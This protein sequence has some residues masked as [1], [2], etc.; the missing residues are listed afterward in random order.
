LIYLAQAKSKPDYLAHAE[1]TIAATLPILQANAT[2]APLL[3]TAIPALVDAKAK[4][5]AKK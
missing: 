3:A 2:A 5:Q 1:K 4:S